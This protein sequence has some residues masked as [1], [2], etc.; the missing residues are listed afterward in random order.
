MQYAARL[1]HFRWG[2]FLCGSL[3]SLNANR[4]RRRTPSHY[5]LTLWTPGSEKHGMTMLTPS[6]GTVRRSRRASIHVQ[7]LSILGQV[8][9]RPQHRSPTPIETGNEGVLNFF[10]QRQDVHNHQSWHQ[11]LDSV[12]M[13]WR[14]QLCASVW[15]LT[16]MQQSN[17]DTG[18]DGMDGRWIKMKG[19]Y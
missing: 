11:H 3:R 9:E 10:L 2:I 6:G 19:K 8:E 12:K 7:H 18:R 5:S 13:A 17:G 16:G 4:W 14:G 15:S 1:S